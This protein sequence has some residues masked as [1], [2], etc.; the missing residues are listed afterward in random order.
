MTK[1]LAES[2]RYA[3]LLELTG[4]RDNS[5]FSGADIDARAMFG[6]QAGTAEITLIE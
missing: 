5:E 4:V 2:S 1:E 3:A 6:R